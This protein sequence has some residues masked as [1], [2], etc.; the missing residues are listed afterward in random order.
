MHNKEL[1]SRIRDHSPPVNVTLWAF[2]VHYTNGSS[3][4]PAFTNPENKHPK[5]DTDYEQNQQTNTTENRQ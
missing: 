2:V 4:V 5:R 1:R 3:P